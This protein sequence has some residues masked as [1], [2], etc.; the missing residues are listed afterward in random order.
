[1]YKQTSMHH[2]YIIWLIIKLLN[3]QSRKHKVM[4]DH[5]CLTADPELIL[6]I[7]HGNNFRLKSQIHNPWAA[8]DFEENL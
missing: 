5:V 7:L 3:E 4:F 2:T 6:C 1:M 8:T